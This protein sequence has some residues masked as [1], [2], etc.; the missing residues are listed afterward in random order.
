[1]QETSSFL[2]ILV[3][4]AVEILCSVELSKPMQAGNVNVFLSES[5]MSWDKQPTYLTTKMYSSKTVHSIVLRLKQDLF[6][7]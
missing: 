2:G 6:R 5:F 4:C 1:M 3:P 7:Y